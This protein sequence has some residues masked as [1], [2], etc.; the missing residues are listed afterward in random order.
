MTI[1]SRLGRLERELD[2][3]APA[4]PIALALDV[5]DAG[6]ALMLVD[7]EWQPCPDSRGVLLRGPVKL[8]LGWDP[9]IV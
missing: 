6:T 4:A 5:D 2:A 1:S 7:S 9:R 8:Y 3:R